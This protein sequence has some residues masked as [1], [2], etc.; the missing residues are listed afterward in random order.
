MLDFLSSKGVVEKGVMKGPLRMLVG[1][2]KTLGG[3]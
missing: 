3:V 2:S 1:I